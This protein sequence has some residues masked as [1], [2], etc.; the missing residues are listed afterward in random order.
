MAQF[1][2][3]FVMHFSPAVILSIDTAIEM[4]RFETLG[5][6]L[7]LRD[8][9]PEMMIGAPM[10][11]AIYTRDPRLALWVGGGWRLGSIGELGIDGWRAAAGFQVSLGGW[12]VAD[13]LWR[14]EAV[15]GEGENDFSQASLT[16]GLCFWFNPSY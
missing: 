2:G 9:E 16:T 12:W 7:E 8:R 4:V 6:D 10:L 3:E 14:V 1:Y 11:K 15:Y 5:T 13:A